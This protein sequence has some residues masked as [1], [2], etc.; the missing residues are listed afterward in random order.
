MNVIRC[1]DYNAASAA[2]SEIFTEEIHNNPNIVLGL[3]TGSTPLGLYW[4][5][6]SNYKKGLI[7]FK[8]VVTY[9]LDE[10]VGLSRFN[11]Q[12][13]YYYMFDNLFNHVDINIKN[14]HIPYA[15]DGTD[16]QGAEEYSK[17]LSEKEIDIQLLGIGANGH[18]A[19]NEPGTSFDQET[20]IVE[21]TEETRQDNQRFFES[22][23]DVPTKAISMGI[24][25]ILKAK[26]IV[27]IATGSTKANAVKR[28]L[29]K[30]ITTDFPAS[31][32]HIHPNVTV[33]IDEEAA[34][35]L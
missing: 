25:D 26:R 4:N 5:L 20:F 22:I 27:L 29:S 32:L 8:D 2:A 23:D 3:A 10:Y 18:I 14:I 7:S 6:I 30:E 21:L 19:F 35:L 15:Y 17:K 9:N 28:L 16:N 33:I 11:P 1:K 24:K 34:S 12:S 31:A 13:Y